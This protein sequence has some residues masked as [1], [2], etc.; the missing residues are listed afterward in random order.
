MRHGAPS[1]KGRRQP[2]KHALQS[3]QTWLPV[4]ERNRE[5]SKRCATSKVRTR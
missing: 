4:R 1:K 3:G 2:G 5:D